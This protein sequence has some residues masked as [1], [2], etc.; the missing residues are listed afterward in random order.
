[1][2]GVSSW[3]DL[4][5]RSLDDLD[6]H[7]LP[8]VAPDRCTPS[9]TLP[10][11]AR[12][13]GPIT[14]WSEAPPPRGHVVP[15]RWRP[16]RSAGGAELPAVL[17]RHLLAWE[18]D[19][20]VVID[21]WIRCRRFPGDVRAAFRSPRGWQAFLAALAEVL[22]ERVPEA[23]T[24]P[25]L[26]LLE[27]ATL[28][29]TL[30][31]VARTAAAPTP[32]V[33]VL[34][35][36]AAGWSAIPALV[37]RAL[38][39]TPLVLTEHGVF[40]REAYLAAA[41]ED[42]SPGARFAAT[43][44]A[45][46]LARA[47]YAG[48]DV[49]APVTDA[50]ASWERGLGVEP[51]RILPLYNGVR[52]AAVPEAPPGAASVVTVGRIDALKDF[53]TTLH[54]AAEALR[55]VPQARF[56]HYGPVAPDAEAYG[57]SCV[58]LHERL[59]LRDHFRFMGP[60]DDPRRAMRDADV[61]LMT[62]ISEGLP[63]VLLE[64]MGQGRPVVATGVGGVPEVVRGCGVVCPPGDAHGLAMGVVTLLR[65]PALAW[66]L[67]RR[68]HDRLSRIFTETA[69]VEGYRTLLRTMAVAGVPA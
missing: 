17:V 10:P 67:G 16:R 20:R 24:P 52:P 1:M 49:V 53:H 35:V 46:G 54:V 45:R 56:R 6:W 13:H 23:G 7:V 36:T 55:H 33:D 28:Y 32:A 59:A 30:H 47:A 68:G 64:A 39:G 66:R 69:C 61:V 12:L 38:H 21:A 51:E 15:Q 41:R 26:D 22:D 60:T 19:P 40:V 25:A 11:G 29:Q 3:C 43:R 58:A 31:W 9:Y 8:I 37:H 44:L 57:R 62:S 14:V 5:V 48:A 65:H 4:L 2:G 34:H 27:A 63:M 42:A 18:G 50:N